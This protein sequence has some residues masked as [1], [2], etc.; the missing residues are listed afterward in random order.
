MRSK[1]TYWVVL[2]RVLLLFITL[3]GFSFTLLK[4]FFVVDFILV[5]IIIF[6]GIDFSPTIFMDR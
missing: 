3:L 5:P 6:Q 2:G 1:K 4:E